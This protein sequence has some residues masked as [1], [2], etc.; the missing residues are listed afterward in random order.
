[1]RAVSLSLT[2]TGIRPT[3]DERFQHVPTDSPTL[4]EKS[5]LEGSWA[6]PDEEFFAAGAC[7]VLAGTFLETYPSAGFRALLIQPGE[8]FRGRH[9]VAA[10]SSMVFDCRGWTPR[11][12]FLRLYSEAYCAVFPGWTYNL[13]GVDDPIGWNFCNEHK[14]RHPS[15]FIRSPD[16]RAKA[17]LLGFPPPTVPFG[18]KT[19]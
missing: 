14:H 12:Q 13:V 4:E 10:S 2:L 7:H 15:Q 17:F 9:V 6:R 16:S 11:E 3:S 5:D 18:A 1:M 8:G 19:T